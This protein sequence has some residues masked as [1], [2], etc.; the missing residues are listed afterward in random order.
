MMMSII[1]L[2]IIITNIRL[3]IIPT[4]IIKVTTMIISEVSTISIGTDS[5]GHIDFHRG[6]SIKS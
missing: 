2:T 6:K 1:F 4:T 3:I 5:S